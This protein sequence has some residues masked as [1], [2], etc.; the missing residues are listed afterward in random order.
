MDARKLAVSYS[1]W[2]LFI[3]VFP[4]SERNVNCQ[5][6]CQRVLKLKPGHCQSLCQSLNK[7]VSFCLLTCFSW[8][9]PIDL[10]TSLYGSW[11]DIIHGFFTLLV[12]QTL[13]L[14][15]KNA[16]F[17]GLFCCKT[18]NGLW[19]KS[20]YPFLHVEYELLTKHVHAAVHW[21]IVYIIYNLGHHGIHVKLYW[22]KHAYL[23]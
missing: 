23:D 21:V 6:D 15:L 13:H 4:R 16:S 8:K 17:R 22:R 3:L 12:S 7:L 20:C 2:E 5:M 14:K 1:G 18:E 19:L 11:V 10:A 9:Q